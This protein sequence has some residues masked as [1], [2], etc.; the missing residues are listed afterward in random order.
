MFRHF[1]AGDLSE[2]SSMPV[3]LHN[4][5][6]SVQFLFIRRLAA[7]IS[8]GFTSYIIRELQTPRVVFVSGHAKTIGGPNSVNEELIGR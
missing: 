2:L 3:D 5:V 6:Q 4:F 1:D 8:T 7:C